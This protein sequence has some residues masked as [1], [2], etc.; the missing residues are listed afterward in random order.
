MR[1]ILGYGE[2]ILSRSKISPASNDTKNNE[3]LKITKN[4]V[5]KCG[6]SSLINSSL[7]AP[8][9]ARDSIAYYLVNS[10]SREE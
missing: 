2:Q 9:L 8:L 4:E 5:G 1:Y 3:V 10:N 6:Y 7:T